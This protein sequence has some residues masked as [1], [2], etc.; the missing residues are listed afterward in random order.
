MLD[1]NLRYS[2]ILI[3]WEKK[4]AWF[5]GLAVTE[6]QMFSKDQSLE[7]FLVW[8]F[9]FWRKKKLK[10]YILLFFFLPIQENK[11][12]AAVYL[13]DVLEASSK[14]SMQPYQLISSPVPMYS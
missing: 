14:H 7:I 9:I 3:F 5:Q 4:K 8:T 13:K 2:M 1:L 11:F 6:L 12:S 10:I